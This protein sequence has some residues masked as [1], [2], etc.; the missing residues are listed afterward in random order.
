MNTLLIVKILNK[1]CIFARLLLMEKLHQ[2]LQSQVPKICVKA[3]NIEILELPSEFFN[4]IIENIFI[5]KDQIILS[6]LYIGVD[7]FSRNLV[8][9]IVHIFII[10]FVLT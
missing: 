4:S 10:I 5:S 9:L 3:S 2:A 6:S 7:H 8:I 1:I